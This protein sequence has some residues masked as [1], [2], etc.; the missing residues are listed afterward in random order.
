MRIRRKSRSTPF[1]VSIA[2]NELYGQYYALLALADANSTV[3][4]YPSEF[5]QRL[6]KVD[7]EQIASDRDAIL[8]DWSSR[9]DN[10][11]APK[12]Q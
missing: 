1:S 9:F 2:A 8:K 3:K 4:N 12:K 11:S 10:K 6:V 5:A 7:F